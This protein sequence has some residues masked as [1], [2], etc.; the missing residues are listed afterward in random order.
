[1]IH[2]PRGESNLSVH[3]INMDGCS[4]G[5]EGVHSEIDVLRIGIRL[6]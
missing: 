6:F 5:S 2:Q 3:V 4:P 1:M